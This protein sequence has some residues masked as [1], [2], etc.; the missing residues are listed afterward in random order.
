MFHHSKRPVAA[1]LAVA[2]FALCLLTVVGC[3]NGTG[4][5]NGKAIKGNPQPVTY[6]NTWIDT[7]GGVSDY[8]THS[9]AYDSSHN[10]LYAGCSVPFI[11]EHKGVWKHKG[12]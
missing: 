12:Q 5:D 9:L 4:K 6:I 3:G 7:A 10:L 1:V 8:A 2:S 11:N